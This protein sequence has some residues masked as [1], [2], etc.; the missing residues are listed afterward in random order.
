MAAQAPEKTKFI[1]IKVVD[2]AKADKPA[3]NVRM[4]VGVVKWAM[5][6]A[7]GFS[8]EMKGVDIDWASIEA[9]I[10]SGE[11]GKLVEVED[12]AQHKTV[13]IWVE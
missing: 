1:K 8:P 3:V 9:M 5:K 6:M 13:E 11:I 2:H 10:E 12:E 7:Q 4:P